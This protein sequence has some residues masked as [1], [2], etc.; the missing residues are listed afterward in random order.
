MNTFRA[1]NTDY[2]KP[3]ITIETVLVSRNDATRIFFLYNHEGT[4]Y[5]VFQSTLSLFGFLLNKNDCQLHFD[6]DEEVDRFF[7]TVII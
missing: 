3:W 6:S 7:A 5:R 1:I 4:S 2:L